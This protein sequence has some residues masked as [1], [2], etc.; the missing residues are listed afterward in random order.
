MSGLA[1]NLAHMALW[2]IYTN[3]HLEYLN[4]SDSLVKPYLSWISKKWGVSVYNRVAVYLN[5]S[6]TSETP[7]PKKKLY[8]LIK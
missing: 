8:I 6:G 2:E 1:G 3:F 4:G 7:P 5:F